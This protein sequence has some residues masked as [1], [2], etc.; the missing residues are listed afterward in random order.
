MINVIVSGYFNPYHAGHESYIN[1]AIQI[2]YEEKRWL[3]EK[4]QLHIVINSDLQVNMKGSCPFYSEDTRYWMMK[5]LYPKAKIHISNSDDKTICWDLRRIK[6]M[7]EDNLFNKVIFCNGGDVNTETVSCKEM[8][9]CAEFGIIARFGV[10]GSYKYN[11]SSDYIKK[12]IEWHKE[13][14]NAQASIGNEKKD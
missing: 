12:V 8:T 7:S 14:E 5:R 3:F 2:G 1:H 6:I 13:K 4:V 10:G 11:S 9:Q